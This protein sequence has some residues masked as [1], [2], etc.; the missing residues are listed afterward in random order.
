M[1]K[2]ELIGIKLPM[3]KK[4][5]DLGKL[6]IKCAEKEK[7]GIKNNDIIVVAETIVSKAEGNLIDLN[8]V[9]CSEFAKNSQER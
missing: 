5:D 8:K 9:E 3:I 6:I 2:I 7:V 4:G 1:Q